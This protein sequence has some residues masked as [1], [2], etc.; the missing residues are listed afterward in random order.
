MIERAEHHLGEDLMAM[1]DGGADL[2]AA[3]KAE[4]EAHVASCPECQ[5]ALASARAVLRAIDAAEQPD[6]SASFDRALFARL[7][8]IDAADRKTAV[9]PRS[10]IERIRAFFT[11]PRI[12]IAVAATAGLVI[13]VFFSIDRQPIDTP[14][15]VEFAQNLEGLR[16]ADNLDL[17]RNLDVV[18]NLDVLDDLET[19]QAMEEEP[20]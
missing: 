9:S 14:T 13:A 6:V 20:G 8:S 19:I 7:D 11:L 1:A 5:E 10:F 15:A 18:E 3:R 2:P 17:Y 4:L 12:G 16:V